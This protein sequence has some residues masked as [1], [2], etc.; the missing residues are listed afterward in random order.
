MRNKKTRHTQENH[1]NGQEATLCDRPPS[2]SFSESNTR[3]RPPWTLSAFG[4]PQLGRQ[5]LIDSSTATLTRLDIAVHDALGVEEL[6][7]DEDLP[8]IPAGTPSKQRKGTLL[9]LTTKG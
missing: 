1:Y 8:R 5:V 2:L 9:K 3:R 6:E 7:S 4:F